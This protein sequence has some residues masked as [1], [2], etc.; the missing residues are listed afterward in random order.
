MSQSFYNAVETCSIQSDTPSQMHIQ[1]D[2][3]RSTF[4]S[5]YYFTGLY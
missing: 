2:V 5:Y 4:R 1:P 3:R